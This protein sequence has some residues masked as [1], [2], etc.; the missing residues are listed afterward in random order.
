MFIITNRIA[1]NIQPI[2]IC[3]ISELSLSFQRQNENKASD[4]GR[5]YL[6]KRTDTEVAL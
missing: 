3:T 1:P 6:A 2:P 4:F 5:V